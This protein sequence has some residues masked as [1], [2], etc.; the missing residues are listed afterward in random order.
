MSKKSTV[1]VC[2]NCGA[3][4]PKW[5]GKCS[6]CGAFATAVEEIVHAQSKKM[7]SSFRFE[8]PEAK[9]LGDYKSEN[10]AHRITSDIPEWDLLIGGG[11]MVGS[12]NLLGGEPGIGKS[13][14]MLQIARSYSQRNYS[15]L[16]ISGE[17]S[18]SQI[19]SRAERLDIE[20]K[21]IHLLNTTDIELIFECLEKN[22]LYKIVIIDSI[23][24]IYSSDISSIPG[25]ISQIREVT[26]RL[27]EFAKKR[28][29]S[30]F[31]I[32]HVT[33]TGELAGPKVLEHI[34]DG[35]FYFESDKNHNLRILRAIK[36]RF[37]P[38]NE[39]AVFEMTEKGLV[40]SGNP[41]LLFTEKH[42]EIPGGYATGCIKE[43]SRYVMV[44]FQSL[45]VASSYGV[46]QRV[47]F[48]IEQKRGAIIIAILEKFLSL[49]LG[50]FDIFIN[51]SG[52]LKVTDP[53]IDAALIAAI[54][55]SLKGLTMKEP[56]MFLGEATLSGLL[57]TPSDASRRINEATKL[58]FKKIVVPP[59]KTDREKD[60]LSKSQK[61][62]LV[63]CKNIQ[64]LAKILYNL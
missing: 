26:F 55:T 47:S 18:P 11:L 16:Y 56:V 61:E 1:F 48:G 14:L 33:K 41:S 24:T 29:L 44:E 34:V 15:V 58:G 54:F 25:S 9:P 17:E 6:E 52:G 31:I 63:V 20:D 23:Q 43:G 3:E 37:G 35:V 42:D 57:R 5:F 62:K 51:V 60:G 46:P 39:L 21:S 22:P 30:V 36:N 10:N 40:S 27:L 12:I 28:D 2:N 8:K 38:V 45:A 19:A 13:T 32:G 49:E 53:F 7:P 50:R 4:S 59:L 64:D